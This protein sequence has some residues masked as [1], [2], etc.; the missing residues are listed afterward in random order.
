MMDK[1]DYKK[2]ITGLH[3]ELNHKKETLDNEL[4]KSKK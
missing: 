2:Y 3:K 4:Y 1:N